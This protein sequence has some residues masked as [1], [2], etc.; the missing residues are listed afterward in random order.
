MIRFLDNID[1]NNT[2]K[3]VNIPDPSTDSDLAKAG[4]VKQQIENAV[5]DSIYQEPV[6]A[7]QVDNTL[8]PG[9][10]P[11]ENDR[12]AITNSASLNE[13]FGTIE[14]I[15][16]NVIVEYDGTKFNVVFDIAAIG[17]GTIFFNKATGKYTQYGSTGLEPIDN[18]ADGVTYTAG[19]GISIEGN[20]ISATSTKFVQDIGDGTATSFEITHNFNTLDVIVQLYNKEDGT[21]VEATV[22]RT[23]VNKVTI[24]V[25][26]APTANA[27]RVVVLS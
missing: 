9:A 25:G 27:L 23:D 2:T 11:A 24:T 5:N 15:K 18:N 13:H 20:V 7:I 3:I 17:N 12:Y 8:D 1:L 26:T 10:T 16:N 4:Y 21:T 22:A 14:G 19:T 6:L